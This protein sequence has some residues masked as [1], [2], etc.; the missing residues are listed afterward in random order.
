MRSRRGASTV[1]LAAGGGG[2]VR[3]EPSVSWAAEVL[4]ALLP[5]PPLAVAAPAASSPALLENGSSSSLG[6][7]SGASSS[8]TL[9]SAGGSSAGDLAASSADVGDSGMAV[10][11]PPSGEAAPAMDR[12]A[13]PDFFVETAGGDEAAAAGGALVV[14]ATPSAVQAETAAADAAAAPEPVGLTFVDV[15][16]RLLAKGLERR[17]FELRA[18]LRSVLRRGEARRTLVESA[19][20]DAELV[21]GLE[22]QVTT[23]KETRPLADPDQN[24]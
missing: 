21:Q 24:E 1:S 4:L 8:I 13:S 9:S 3:D 17:W 10:D 18:P 14:A 23:R 16:Q 20:G 5:Q 7:S 11:G 15:Q 19:S 12:N 6:D 22:D 2:S